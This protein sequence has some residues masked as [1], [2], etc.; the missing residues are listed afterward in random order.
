MLLFFAATT[1]HTDTLYAACHACCCHERCYATSRH[2]MVL[3]YR[4]AAGYR[5]RRYADMR[6]VDMPDYADI[7][8]AGSSAIHD[9]FL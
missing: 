8:F 1:F 7:F 3:L 4:H 9:Y 5:H 2:A 6:Y